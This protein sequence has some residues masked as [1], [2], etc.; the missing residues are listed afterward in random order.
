MAVKAIKTVKDFK[1]MGL[2][3]EAEYPVIGTTL[4]V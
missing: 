4:I 3:I 1:A 2:L